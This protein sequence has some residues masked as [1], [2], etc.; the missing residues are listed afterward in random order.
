MYSTQ[1]PVPYNYVE[2]PKPDESTLIY[3]LTEDLRPERNS[4]YDP[5]LV[6]RTYVFVEEPELGKEKPTYQNWYF[7]AIHSH[8]N[9][10]LQIS[11]HFAKWATAANKL[12]L[13]SDS[14]QAYVRLQE[15]PRTYQKDYENFKK[16]FVE[17]FE[18]NKDN[19]SRIQRQN[20]LKEFRALFELFAF[21]EQE[22][23]T[24]RVSTFGP[25]LVRLF[26][27]KTGIVRQGELII[28][29]DYCFPY[30]E[31]P[32]YYTKYL[33]NEEYR[34]TPYG[35]HPKTIVNLYRWGLFDIFGVDLAFTVDQNGIV[36]QRAFVKEAPIITNGSDKGTVGIYRVR[37]TPIHYNK[38]EQSYW[39]NGT[40]Q[41]LA[42]YSSRLH[43]YMEAYKKA[44]ELRRR[45]DRV[46]SLTLFSNVFYNTGNKHHFTPVHGSPENAQLVSNM[47]QEQYYAPL[48]ANDGELWASR[49]SH[50]LMGDYFKDNI[51]GVKSYCLPFHP[52][53]RHHNLKSRNAR[54]YVHVD[55]P[56]GLKAAS[57]F[58]MRENIKR[59]FFPTPDQLREMVA[60]IRILQSKYKENSPD[61]VNLFFCLNPRHVLGRIEE[62]TREII[63]YD[64]NP[65]RLSQV[66]QPFRFHLGM[67]DGF[68]VVPDEEGTPQWRA[69]YPYA[70]TQKMYNLM[71]SENSA[72]L[73]E[74][75]RQ[76]K[77]FIIIGL[78][79]ISIFL[80][81]SAA[82]RYAHR[83]GDPGLFEEC[84]KRKR[85][86]ADVYFS[87]TQ[88]PTSLGIAMYARLIHSA[89][90]EYKA[91]KEGNRLIVND[92]GTPTDRISK[93]YEDVLLKNYEELLALNVPKLHHI[94]PD[95][96]K[97]PT[98]VEQWAEWAR[99]YAMANPQVR[100]LD[101]KIRTGFIAQMHTRS[102]ALQ[103][104]AGS[105]SKAPP[106]D[107]ALLPGTPT[108]AP[109]RPANAF[110][111]AELGQP[112]DLG[113]DALE[114]RSGDQGEAGETVD[115]EGGDANENDSSSDEDV[116]IP[117][118]KSLEE[119]QKEAEEY[120]RLMEQEEADD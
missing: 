20:P 103:T 111:L 71:H 113:E 62:G 19:T 105:Y 2:A 76:D 53:S 34:D 5:S 99:W 8:S 109:E 29:P 25:Y 46:F 82:K 85:N 48:N 104:R 59:T 68:F 91:F 94:H 36:H 55:G 108:T 7:K 120:T 18:A 35:I 33:V 112:T 110:V 98:H 61:V 3:P 77:F 116:Y 28:I 66:G 65:D 100:E 101:K 14:V 67:E 23:K 70:P 107:Q 51:S 74:D 45:N 39:S 16:V 54:Q 93:D 22:I 106:Q 97:N 10:M 15:M 50:N 78:A 96:E 83:V 27:K 115:L 49:L 89:Y 95:D 31:N 92:D 42:K 26:R 17:T 58:N 56:S 119:L 37:R 102:T 79:V 60:Y 24:A 4:F 80:S 118:N 90:A 52:H 1:Q 6:R 38:R 57:L 43:T 75:I 64:D 21:T 41:W 72:L 69:T 32:T 40:P 13:L 12:D 44:D 63:A 47:M 87:A 30:P 73:D 84:K 88:S 117:S 114:A 9:R 81:S 86:P 11:H